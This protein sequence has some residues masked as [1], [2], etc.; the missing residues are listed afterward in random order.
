MPLN[1]RVNLFWLL[2]AIIILAPLIGLITIAVYP[3]PFGHIRE[4][5]PVVLLPLALYTVF[6]AV[7]FGAW[8]LVSNLSEAKISPAIDDPNPADGF[9]LVAATLA[10]AALMLSQFNVLDVLTGEVRKGELRGDGQ[11]IASLKKFAIPALFAYTALLWRTRQVSLRVLLFVGFTTAAVGISTGS[12]SGMLV[13]IAPGI[14]AAFYDG[15]R[16]KHLIVALGAGTASL[17]AFAALF[18]SRWSLSS[19]LWY[20]WYRTFPQTAEI[21][22]RMTIRSMDPSFSFE[23]L[24]SLFFVVTNTVLRQVVPDPENLYQYT[25]N[26]AISGELYP[27]RIDLI[28]TMEWNH[29]PHVYIE[30]L[31]ALGFYG[32][33]VYAII[34]ALAGALLMKAIFRR[35]GAG[36]FALAS[37][38]CTYF[39]VVYSA[40]VNSA[41]ITGLVHPFPILTLL[42]TWGLLRGLKVVG[43]LFRAGAAPRTS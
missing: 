17:L 26:R 32:F 14:L 30:G 2:P 19:S 40:W 34:A 24:Q 11:V 33:W 25:F 6:A 20:V 23:Y 41:G 27:E 37:V 21:P 16:V 18:D 8:A 38:L 10:L 5:A 29:T 43:R 4:D 1:Q 39:V 12:K 15:M 3:E 22:Y 28:R 31:M 9:V 7:F 42:A 36:D 35:I 13:A